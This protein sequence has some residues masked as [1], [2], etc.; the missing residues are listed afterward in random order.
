VS[1]VLNNSAGPSTATRE[2]VLAAAADLGYRP[3]RTASLLARRRSCLIG[4][5]L[6]V[7]N[8]F[9]AEL[10]ADLH[11]AAEAAGYDLL[12]STITPTRDS[13]RA[14]ET[15]MDSRCEALILLGPDAPSSRLTSLGEQMPVVVIGRRLRS[16]SVD[17]I[18][19]ADEHGVA[20]AV[21]HLVG[22]GHRRIAYADGLRGTIA[23]DRRSGYLRGLRR[24]GLADAA[25]VVAGG[26]TELSGSRAARE[27]LAAEHPPTAVIA[28]NDR[29]AL[30][31]L[32]GLLRAGVSVPDA[33]SVIGYDDSPS[34]H[35]PQVD[36]T[37][38]SQDTRRQAEEAVAAVLER[39]DGG[40]TERREVVLEPRLVVRRT[41]APPRTTGA[42]GLVSEAGAESTEP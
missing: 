10:V 14:I 27:L 19:S 33:M 4:A 3:D 15:L 41:T 23:T 25:M 20:A 6:D 18:R 26:Q 40:R 38:V 35:L 24:H 32:D 39:L 22:L 21:D 31:L 12:L 2:R 13:R 7:R 9:H 1:L 16:T 29:A 11:D 42:L 34:A 5:M 37:T 36:L 28:F 30:G 8:T 17:V